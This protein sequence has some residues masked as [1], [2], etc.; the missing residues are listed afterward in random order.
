MDNKEKYLLGNLNWNP[1][2]HTKSNLQ[3]LVN[4][5]KGE[6]TTKINMHYFEI[7]NPQEDEMLNDM[8]FL[9]MFKGE[10]ASN[11]ELS[12]LRD[13]AFDGT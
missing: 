10:L 12:Q 9:N 8:E 1:K 5:D 7:I 11:N 2:Q 13:S 3:T 4:I 6:D